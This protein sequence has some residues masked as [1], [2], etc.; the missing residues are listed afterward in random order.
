[1]FFGC[2][3]AIVGG[4]LRAGSVHIAILLVARFIS[5]LGIGVLVITVPLW[6]S[7]ISSPAT[8]GA[9]VGVHGKLNLITE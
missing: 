6:Q 1:M 7:E 3:L 4:A 9:L 5:G 2:L 8:R